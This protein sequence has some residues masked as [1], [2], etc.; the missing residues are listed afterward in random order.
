[1]VLL[2]ALL[3]GDWAAAEA[4]EDWTRRQ[5]SGVVSALLQ[6][7]LES[8]IRSWRH[9]ERS[10]D[11]PAGRDVASLGAGRVAAATTVRPDPRSVV[12]R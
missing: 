6:W 3:A 10:V 9:V 2:G 12:S 8:G 1:M 11:G 5:A 4:G 7:T